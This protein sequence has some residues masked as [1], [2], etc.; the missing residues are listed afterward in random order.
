MSAHRHLRIAA[1]ATLVCGVLAGPGAAGASASCEGVNATP[2]VASE[3]QLAE[4]SV[5]LLNEARSNRGLRKLR[6]NGRL[7]QAARSHTSDMVRRHY[8]AHVSRSG[9]DVVDRLRATGYIRPS[10]SWIVGENLAWGTG[11]LSTPLNIFRAW[12]RS[13]GHRRNI[14]TARFREIGI[15]V[16]LQAPARGNRLGATYTTTFGAYR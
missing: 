4:S 16:A 10:T 14:L 12:M 11:R 13:P 3:G 1:C 7:S 15:G 8:F 2:A 6:V 9:H 5:C